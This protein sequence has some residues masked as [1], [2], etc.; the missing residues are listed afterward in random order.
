[1][2]WDRGGVRLRND[3]E[4]ELGV[5]QDKEVSAG[6]IKYGG[7]WDTGALNIVGAGRAGQERKVRVWDKLCVGNE[8]LN[9]ADINKV[10]A[11]AD[12]SLTPTQTGR[13]YATKGLRNGQPLRCIDVPGSRTHNGNR[14]IVYDCHWETNQ[15]FY[16]TPERQI[17]S[18]L[19]NKCV[20]VSAGNSANGTAIQLW[21]CDANNKNQKFVRNTDTSAFHWEGNPRKCID[22]PGGNIGNGTRLQLWDCNGSEAQK[23]VS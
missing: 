14:M 3:Q 22:L 19:G 15:Q 7:P 2:K 8:C 13:I 12:I 1:M 20:D 21:D 9:S 17:K 6:K 4:I 11:Q 10:K 18:V 23:F 16:V 5:G